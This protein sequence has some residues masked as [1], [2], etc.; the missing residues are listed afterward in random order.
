M[1]ESVKTLRD[2]IKSAANSSQKADLLNDLAWELRYENTKETL[3]LSSKALKLSQELGYDRGIAY[4]KLHQAVANFLLSNEKNLVQDLLDASEYFESTE[5]DET[6]LPVCLNF[7]AR[8][9]EGYGNYEYGLNYAQKALKEAKKIG[10][11]EGEGDIL[12][13]L[14]LIYS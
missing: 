10:Y 14:G 12:S 2:K 11:F 5:E 7:L 4:G 3:E 9:Y 6:G 13:N 1:E 8:V